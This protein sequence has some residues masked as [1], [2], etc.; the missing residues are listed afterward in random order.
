[1]GMQ[2]YVLGKVGIV[3]KGAGSSGLGTRVDLIQHKDNVS[4]ILYTTPFSIHVV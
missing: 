1:M 3:F 4:G 2:F